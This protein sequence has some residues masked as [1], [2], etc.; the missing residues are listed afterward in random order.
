MV[1]RFY[2][3]RTGHIKECSV[4]SMVRFIS[5]MILL[6]R[7]DPINICRSMISF[8]LAQ[9]HFVVTLLRHLAIVNRPFY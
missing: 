1:N 8:I 7:H 5:R 2:Y 3:E 9:E 6:V 4:E